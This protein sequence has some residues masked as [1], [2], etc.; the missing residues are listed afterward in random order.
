MDHTRMEI[1]YRKL[2]SYIFEHNEEPED[3]A[4]VLKQLGFNKADVLNELTYHCGF[5]F[6][7]MSELVNELY[8]CE[9][10]WWILDNGDIIEITSKW[11]ED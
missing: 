4:S 8:E 10:E 2:I 9:A 6:D 11:I 5:D 1:Y 7:D 3:F